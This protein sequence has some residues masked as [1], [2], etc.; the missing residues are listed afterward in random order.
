M[1]PHDSLIVRLERLRTREHDCLVQIVEGLVE[2]LRT[3]AHLDLGYESLWKLLVERL[4]YSEGAASRRVNAA[5][6][7]LR[8]PRALELLRER[9]VTL[10]ALARLRPV[11]DEATSCEELLDKI[12][13]RNKTE[14]ERVVAAARPTPARRETVRRRF[15][16][17]KAPQETEPLF[18]STVE[19]LV[20]ERVGLSFS[21]D[22]QA[23]AD[24]ERVKELLSNKLPAG[25]TLEQAFNELVQFYLTKN[26]P[27]R[28]VARRRQRTSTAVE[29]HATTSTVEASRRIPDALRDEILV[30]DGLK[31]AFVGQGGKRCNGTHELQIDHVRPFALGGKTARDNLR[32]LCGAHNRHRARQTFER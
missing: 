23:Y 16:K 21:L 32:V 3:R 12:E 18:T 8:C 19:A 1:I 22:P 2:C 29:V 11:L 4:S 17:P 25:M 7:V 27:K 9:K 15:E 5:Q 13:G 30:R 10:C 26:D 14:V 24:F 28:R 20:V 31:C 6:V